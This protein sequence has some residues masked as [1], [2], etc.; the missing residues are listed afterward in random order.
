[1]LN[2]RQFLGAAG[3]LA[4]AAVAGGGVW[5]ALL[6]DSVEKSTSPGASTTTTTSTIAATTTT[7]APTTTLPSGNR[8]LVVVQM[9]GGNDGLN[10]LIPATGL[11]R[12]A[13]PILG[14]PE[15]DLIEMSKT[16]YSMHPSLE[17]LGK[18]WEIGSMTAVEGVGIPQQSRSHFKSTDTWMAGGPSATS[19]SGW[20]GRWMD[21]TQDGDPDPLRAIALA[22]GGPMLVG[23]SSLATVIQSAEAF[24]LRTTDSTD[25]ESLIAAF[26]ATAS[27]VSSD[28]AMAAAQQAIPATVDA[29]DLLGE[30]FSESAS[31]GNGRGV[32][33]ADPVAAFNAAARIIDLGIGTQVITIGLNGYDTHSNQL[34]RQSELLGTLA[35]GVSGFLD[36]IEADGHAE[37]VLVITMSEFGRRVGENG[38]GGTDHGQGGLQFLFGRDVN[39]WDVHGELDLANLANGDVP[40]KVD[41]RSVYAEVLDWLG[42][43][44]DEILGQSFER[45]GVLSA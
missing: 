34:A 20:L 15:T 19:R 36:Q 10:T 22:G 12:D 28:P 1:M 41:E 5:A 31:E 45:I 44:T 8:T 37:N 6:R 4:G 7:A 33:R 29:V 9:A 32:S 3:G 24:Q 14:I 21:A 26:L 35:T 13:R 25:A 27:P 30:V 40:T 23:E 17:P 18:W 43:P 42:G 38:S 11:Y 39:G 16:D 2:R